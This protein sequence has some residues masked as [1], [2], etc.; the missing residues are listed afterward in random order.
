MKAKSSE[1]YMEIIICLIYISE[2]FATRT[3]TGIIDDTI[4]FGISAYYLSFRRSVSDL[5]NQI[6]KK[7]LVLALAERQTRLRKLLY[8]KSTDDLVLAFITPQLSYCSLFHGMTEDQ[9][10]NYRSFD[11][12]QRAWLRELEK[13]IS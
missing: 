7:S 11:M 10:N 9:L 12:L 4:T 3:G 6:C 1:M 5:I 8:T 13:T 2:D